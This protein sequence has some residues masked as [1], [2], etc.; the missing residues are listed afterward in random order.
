MTD[1][2]A[3]LDHLPAMVAYWDRECRNRIAN[4][5]Y[6]EW[7]GTR[8]EDMFGMHI[9]DLLGPELYERN[10]PYIRAALAGEAQLFN[11][12][13]VDTSGCT[14]YTQASYVPRVVD[15]AVEGFFVLVTD[16]SERVRAEAALADSVANTALLHE[17]QRIAADMHDLVIQNLYAANLALAALLPGLEASGAEQVGV[18]IDRID[19]AVVTLRAAIHEMTRQIG[20]EQFVADLQQVIDNSAV[21]LGFTPTL[22]VEGPPELIPVAARPEMLAVLQEALSNVVRHAAAT[23]V[24]V[25]VTM[26]GSDVRLV[27]VDNGRGFGEVTR[28]SGITNM[29]VRAERLGGSFACSAND[30]SGTIVD[31]QVPSTLAAPAVPLPRSPAA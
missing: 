18:I 16:I 13:L 22:V 20:P 2:V 27:V 8:P 7:F 10:L 29:R 6:L 15:G 9:R 11:R 3:A 30:P 28:S 23:S 26:L 31:W 12:T 17:R 5:A 24:L 14:R 19:H 4:A 21:G 1:L 25:T